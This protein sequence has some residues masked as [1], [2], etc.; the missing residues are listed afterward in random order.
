MFFSPLRNQLIQEKQSQ[1]QHN[2]WIVGIMAGQVHIITG[3][4]YIYSNNLQIFEN[5]IFLIVY[6]TY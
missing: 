1:N 2:K 4:F 5:F 6:L 3:H